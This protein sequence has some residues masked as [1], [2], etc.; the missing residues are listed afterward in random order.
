MDSELPRT[1][2]DLRARLSALNAQKEE[3]FSKKHALSQQI[4]EKIQTIKKL[5]AER[6]ERTG[7]VKT[8]KEQRTSLNKNITAAAQNLR[9]MHDDKKQLQKKLGLTNDPSRIKKKIDELNER[10]ET[11]VLEFKKEQ[12]IMKQI[13]TLE[14]QYKSMSKATRLFEQVHTHTKELREKK[15]EADGVRGKIQ[16][17]AEES[18][19]RHE[20][21]VSLSAEI[22][23]L[24]QEE[25][26]LDAPIAELK[27]QIRAINEQLA[28]KLGTLTEHKH[29]ERESKSQRMRA[30]LAQKQQAVQQKLER[31]EKL[32]TEDILI[33]QSI[34]EK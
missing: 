20:N 28:Q 21:I 32:N 16:Q 24:K 11:E 26:T 10:I 6:D 7:H 34:E 15:K 31:G 13:R 1:I 27:E 23:K 4:I 5:R 30:L 18:Q 2:Q 22:D 33:L 12:Q 3:L 8:L 17:L 29:T 14:Q 19:T 9:G 25:K